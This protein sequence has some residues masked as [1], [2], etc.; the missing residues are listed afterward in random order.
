MTRKRFKKLLMARGFEIRDTEICAMIALKQYGC[1]QI[2]WERR[3]RHEAQFWRYAMACA[4]AVDEISSDA[5]QR[6]GGLYE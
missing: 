2:A 6:Q 5:K 3:W 1:Y 4:K